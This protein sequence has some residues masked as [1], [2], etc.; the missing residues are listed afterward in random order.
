MHLSITGMARMSLGFL[1]I[2]EY[3]LGRRSARVFFG[4]FFTLSGVARFDLDEWIS[5]AKKPTPRTRKAPMARIAR[6]SASCSFH[7]IGNL[8]IELVIAKEEIKRLTRRAEDAEAG[9]A[10]YQARERAELLARDEAAPD[11]AVEAQKP[12]G[13]RETLHEMFG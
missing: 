10:D 13:I 6:E 4:S 2:P 3:P 5:F 9:V 12:G 8:E 11:Q 1:L 7:R